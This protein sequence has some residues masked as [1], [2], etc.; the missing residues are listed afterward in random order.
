MY[1]YGVAAIIPEM[2]VYGMFVE[3]D[4]SGFEPNDVVILTADYDL[5]I[6]EFVKVGKADTIE[7]ATKILKAFLELNTDD[8]IIKKFTKIEY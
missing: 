2:G 7:E 5:Q 4:E 3:S 8:E 1:A 6:I